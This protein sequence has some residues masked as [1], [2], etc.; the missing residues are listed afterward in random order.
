MEYFT[1]TA[2]TT[3]N[4]LTIGSLVLTI[5]SQVLTIGTATGGFNQTLNVIPRESLTSGLLSITDEFTQVKT[6]IE[7]TGVYTGGYFISDFVFEPILNRFYKLKLFK[8]NQIVW[9]GKAKAVA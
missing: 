1:S 8:N 2:E 7:L 5:N 6:D 3:N 4:V 9:Q